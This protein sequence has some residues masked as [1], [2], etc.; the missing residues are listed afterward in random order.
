MENLLVWGFYFLT[1][2]AFLPGLVSRLFGFRVFKKGITNREIALTFDDGPDPFYTP[3]LL[4]LLARHGARATFFVVGSHAERHP[5]LLQRMRDEGHIIGIH[6]YVHKT[7][8]LMR[9]GRL[10]SKFSEQRK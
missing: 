6:N 10:R 5:E 9:P 1:L 4:D 3:L 2:Y 8:W 7:N